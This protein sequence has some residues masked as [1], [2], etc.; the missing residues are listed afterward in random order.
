MDGRQRQAA[1][2]APAPRRVRRRLHPVGDE[3]LPEDR[4]LEAPPEKRPRPNP[5]MRPVDE[6]APVRPRLHIGR[7]SLLVLVLIAAAFYIGPLREFFAQ[8]DRYQQKT[9]ALKAAEAEHTELQRK[10]DLLSKDSYIGLKALEGSMLVEPGTQVF[11]IKGLPGRAEEVAA[12]TSTSP[13]AESI[14]VLDRLS[15]LW[16]T[17]QQ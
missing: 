10:I 2:S 6:T 16:R 15:D 9:A 17:L 14:S 8:Q 3:E 11:V 1:A 13:E 7:L 4:A 12:S 5:A